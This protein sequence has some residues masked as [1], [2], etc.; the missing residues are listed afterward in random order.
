M[1]L[2][3]Q[4]EPCVIQIEQEGDVP[5]PAACKDCSGLVLCSADATLQDQWIQSVRQFYGSDAPARF[6]EHVLLEHSMVFKREWLH[7]SDSG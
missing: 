4:G 6:H 3:W 2:R 7:E 5:S 1:A